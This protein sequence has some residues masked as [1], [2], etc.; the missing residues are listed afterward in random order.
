MRP[1]PVTCASVRPA[2]GFILPL[3]FF[4]VA[5]DLGHGE[6]LD[7]RIGD[8]LD[9]H[10]LGHSS[11]G[12]AGGAVAHGALGF[13]GGC[14]VFSEAHGAGQQ[15]RRGQHDRGTKGLNHCETPWD[16]FEARTRIQALAV[17]RLM[18][19]ADVHGRWFRNRDSSR[20]H[21]TQTGAIV[22]MVCERRSR[23]LVLTLTLRR[24]LQTL[25][26][27]WRA[28]GSNPPTSLIWASVSLPLKAGILP[29]PLVVS[30]IICASLSDLT[31]GSL[32]GLT[33]I[34]LAMPGFGVPSAP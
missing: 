33:P 7:R 34:I 8:G 14:A 26:L 15:Q 19:P 21:L 16:C 27:T 13:V 18:S 17:V 22:S 6:S 32:T 11:A 12:G 3:P 23:R 20:N 24:A 4:T 5:D 30:A 28:S 25:A 31:E 1:R 9:A 10:G 29:L 2:M